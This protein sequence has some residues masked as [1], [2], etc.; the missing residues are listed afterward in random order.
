MQRF[1]GIDE[2]LNQEESGV[3]NGDILAPVAVKKPKRMPFHYWNV[4]G[5]QY[6]LKLNTAMI[7]AL[8]NK[9]K[10]NVINLVTEDDIPPLSVMLTIIQAAMAPW[11]H[12]ISYEKVRGIYES[13]VD[14]GGNQTD[15]LS[16]VVIPIMAVSGFFTQSQSESILKSMEEVDMLS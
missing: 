5:R 8:E 15:L 3:E 9:Y 14:E 2:E 4:K 10:R 12:G 13:Y 16:K 7:A 1:E 11:E 6:K